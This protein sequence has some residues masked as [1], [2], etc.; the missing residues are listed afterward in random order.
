[1]GTL[2]DIAAFADVIQRLNPIVENYLEQNHLV[3]ENVRVDVETVAVMIT[4]LQMQI[5]QLQEIVED[6][7]PR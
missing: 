3:A 6:A 5:S 2:N 4:A 1:M 7:R